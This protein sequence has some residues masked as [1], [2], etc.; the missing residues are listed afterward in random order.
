MHNGEIKVKSELTKV[1]TFTALWPAK[2]K[3]FDLLKKFG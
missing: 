2:E 3:R 1:S